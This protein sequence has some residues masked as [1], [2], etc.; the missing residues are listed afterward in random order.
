[1]FVHA[2]STILLAVNIESFAGWAKP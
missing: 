2:A 1:M